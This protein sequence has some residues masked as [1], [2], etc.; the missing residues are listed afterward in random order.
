MIFEFSGVNLPEPGIQI[1]LRNRCK[2]RLFGFVVKM[3]D[4]KILFNDVAYLGDFFCY[5]QFPVLLALLLM[6]SF[7]TR[8]VFRVL[9]VNSGLRISPCRVG[10]YPISKLRSKCSPNIFNR[11][12]FAVVESFRMIPSAI[13]LS[14]RK[15]R[16]GRPA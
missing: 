3:T 9:S 4:P 10:F 16:L 2:P 8:H 13:L 12:N 6:G 5:A 11:V 7:F 14:E 15:F 1:V